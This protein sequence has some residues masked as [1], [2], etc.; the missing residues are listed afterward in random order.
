MPAIDPTLG[1]VHVPRTGGRSILAAFGD[2]RGPAAQHA[3]ASVLR[4]AMPEGAFLAGFVRNPW[5]RMASLHA[6]FT[7]G[8]RYYPF[9]EWLMHGQSTWPEG[10]PP[11]QRKPQAWWLDGCDFVGRFE[12][13]QEDF[14]E[15]CDLV[16]A[17][18][19]TLP[20][21]KDQHQRLPHRE[22]FDDETREAFERW[23]AAD[24]DWGYEF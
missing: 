22:V 8:T 3:S 12:H 11:I 6:A 10:G 18:R 21:V 20:H 1:F 5:D 24:L 14:D 19:R 7:G 23:H 4:A 17:E 2:P 13:L 15:L 16:G 9:K